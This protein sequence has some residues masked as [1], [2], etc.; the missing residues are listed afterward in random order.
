MIGTHSTTLAL[1]SLA[2]SS[3]AYISIYCVIPGI[4]WFDFFPVDIFFW[5]I[6]GISLC[7]FKLSFA[8]EAFNKVTHLPDGFVLECLEFGVS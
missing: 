3:G 7:E 4:F 2:S 1:L 6:F 8:L 5:S